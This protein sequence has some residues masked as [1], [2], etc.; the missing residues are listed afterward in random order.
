MA[1]ILSER[2]GQGMILI[3]NC[4]L[5]DPASGTDA[6]RDILTEGGRIRQI[7]EPGTVP[8]Y[9]LGKGDLKIDADGL[10]AV[11]GLVDTHVHFRDPGALYKED[12]MTGARAAAAGGVTSVVLMANTSPPVDNPETLAYVLRKGEQTGIRVHSCANVTAG[13]AG[14]AL[15]DM[16][17]LRRCGAAGF[18]DD[19]KPVLDRELACRAMEEA[20]R[21]GVPISFHEEDPVFIQN[22]GIHAG[23]ASAHF[24]I[25]GSDRQAEIVMVRRDLELALKTGTSIV[26][27]HISAAESVELVRQAKKKGG[28]IHAEATPHHFSM[29]Q[30]DAIRF[31]TLAK[32]NPPLREEVDRLAILEGLRDG[33]ID[34]IATDHAPHA[35][36]EKALPIEKAPS[37]IIGLETSLALGLMY[38]VKPGYLTLSGLIRCMSE[39]PAKLY[40][41][42]AGYLAAGGPADLALF[43]ETESW[44]PTRFFS[45]SQ[46]SPFLHRT[47]CGKVKYTICQ[48]QVV[49][50]DGKE[51]PF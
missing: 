2:T 32:M 38:L 9:G 36:G 33:T 30:E 21:L 24:G 19:G 14:K 5:V 39:N 29:T 1:A 51:T 23:R 27:Q 41:L 12:I 48:G 22:N 44:T 34:I 37:G 6:R 45:K 43:D 16:E 4:R 47:L 42:D 7:A 15:T 11:P 49:Y 17:A 3:Q 26:I 40:G 28:N 13:M 10:I 8:V 25:G 18:T 46:N 20:A 50:E 31:G 35:A